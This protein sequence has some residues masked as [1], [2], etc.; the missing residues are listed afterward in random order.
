MALVIAKWWGV[1]PHVI[2]QYPFRYFKELR[3]HFIEAN[4]PRDEDAEDD[5][6]DWE[7]ESLTGP[8]V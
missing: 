2:W 7:E 6:F 4:R 8:P 1:M 5:D 3:D